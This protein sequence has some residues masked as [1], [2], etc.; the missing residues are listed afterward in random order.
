MA[1]DSW[2]EG[3]RKLLLVLWEE[4]RVSRNKRRFLLNPVL[5]EIKLKKSCTPTFVCVT[6]TLVNFYVTGHRFLINNLKIVTIHDYFRFLLYKHNSWKRGVKYE[7]SDYHYPHKQIALSD[8]WWNI[9][10]KIATSS[11]CIVQFYLKYTGNWGHAV[12]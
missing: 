5:T 7:R 6:V 1:Q 8:F 12:A 11:F 10:C 9:L 2:L 3:S 4:G